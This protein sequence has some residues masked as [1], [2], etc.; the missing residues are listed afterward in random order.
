MEESHQEAT[1]K[2][3]ERILGVLTSY[4]D[5][6]REFQLHNK[7]NDNN[8]QLDKYLIWSLSFAAASPISYYEF[9]IDPMSFSH[10]VENMF[11]TSFLLRVSHLLSI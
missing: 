9:V 11:H 4:H 6:D 7:N 3:V 10:T 2:E 8:S 1:E 5:D